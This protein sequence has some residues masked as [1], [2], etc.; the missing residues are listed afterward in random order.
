MNRYTVLSGRD[1]CNEMYY[2]IYDRVAC[3][4][5]GYKPKSKDDAWDYAERLNEGCEY[6]A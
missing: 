3:M 5:L 2:Q 6:C 1:A 4:T